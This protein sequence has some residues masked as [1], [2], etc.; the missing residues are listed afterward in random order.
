M[1]QR[2]GQKAAGAAGRVE[3]DFARLGVDAVDDELGDGARRVE[4]AGIAGAIAG[5]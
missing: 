5:R 3:Q 2:A 4:F 1:A